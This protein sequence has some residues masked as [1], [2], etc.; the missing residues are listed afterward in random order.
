MRG[1]E[2]ALVRAGIRA[3]CGARTAHGVH[4]MINKERPW[5]EQ[6]AGLSDL[7]WVREP[8]SQMDTDDLEIDGVTVRFQGEGTKYLQKAQAGVNQRTLV[9]MYCSAARGSASCTR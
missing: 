5:I 1:T 2:V 3:N 7:P 8:R 9:F 4:A 6:V